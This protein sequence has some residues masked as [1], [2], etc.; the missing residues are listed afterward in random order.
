MKLEPIV[1]NVDE[2]AASPAK[3]FYTVANTCCP[4][5]LVFR[6]CNRPCCD[7]HHIHGAALSLH[8]ICGLCRPRAAVKKMTTDMLVSPGAAMALKP[9]RVLM[10][11][12]RFT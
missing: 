8:S 12:P 2:P 4:H 6:T 10:V 1:N 11:N 5:R 3:A 9:C 7:S